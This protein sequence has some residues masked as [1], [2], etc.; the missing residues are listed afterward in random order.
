MLPERLSVIQGSLF[1]GCGSLREVTIPAS[2]TEIDKWAFYGCDALEVVHYNGTKAQWDEITGEGKA[3]IE[4]K[5]QCLPS[6][7]QPPVIAKAANPLQIKAKTPAIK[8]QTLKKKS[9]KLKIT[10]LIKFVDKGQGKRSYKIVSA[11][12]G[13]KNVAKWFKINPKTGTLFVRSGLKKGT[14][15]VKIQVKAAGNDMFKAGKKTVTVKIKVK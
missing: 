1:E 8:Y 15:K 12:K 2:V 6:V 10:K 14:F 4:E 7:G 5:V 3:D 11:K 13:D 9:Q